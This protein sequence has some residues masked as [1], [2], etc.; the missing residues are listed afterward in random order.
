M[1]R[2]QLGAV[3]QVYRF[4]LRNNPCNVINTQYGVSKVTQPSCEKEHYWLTENLVHRIKNSIF[5][6]NKNL[7]VVLQLCI[8]LPFAT[9]NDTDARQPFTG[10]DLP[11]WIRI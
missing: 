8:A 7:N 2:S 1:C 10:T 6:F 11:A 3:F 5:R 4:C 9:N